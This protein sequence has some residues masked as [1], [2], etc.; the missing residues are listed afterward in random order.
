MTLTEGHPAET[1]TGTETLLPLTGAQLGIWNAQRLEP[2]SPYYLVGEVLELDGTDRDVELDLEVLVAEIAATVAEAETMRLRFVETADGPRQW[3]A[4][5]HPLAIPVVDLRAEADPRAAADE[6][7]AHIRADAARAASEMT[8]RQLFTYTLLRLSATQVWCVQLYHHLIVDGYSAAMISRRLATRYTATVTGKRLRPNTFGSIAELVAEDVQYRNSEQATLDRDYWTARLDPLPELHGRGGTDLGAAVRTRCAR[9]FLSTETMDELRKLAGDHGCTWADLLIG[10]YLGFVARLRSTTDVVSALPI[11]VRT[12]RTALT[13]PSMAVNVLP[14]RVSVSLSDDLPELGAK[15]AAALS[16]LREHQRYRGEDLVRDLAAPGAGAVLHGVGINLKA[17]DFDL[18]FAGAVGTLRNVAGGPPEELGLTATP[19]DGGRMMLGFEVDARTVSETEVTARV[20]GLARLVR[21]LSSPDRPA[22]GRVSLNAA[23]IDPGW[24]PAA[25]PQTGARSVADIFADMVTA[26][27][28]ETVL[29]DSEKSMTATE[30]AARSYR[31][32]RLLRARGIGTDD[33]VAIALP[34]TADIVACIFAVWEAGA[35]YVVLDPAYPTERLDGLVAAARP[36]LLLCHG[37]PPVT[38]IECEI[39]GLGSEPIET[40]LASLAGDRLRADELATTRRAD[41]M[42]YV[43]FTSGSTGTPKGVVVRSGGLAHLVHRQRTAVYADARARAGGRQLHVAHTTSFAFDASIDPLLWI[44]DGHRIH[45]YGSD[46]QRDADLQIQ[47]FAADAID[48]VDT[49]PSMAAFLVDAGLLGPAHGDARPHSIGT[50]VVGGEALPAALAQ[51]LGDSAARVYNMYGPTEATVDAIAAEVT[52]PDVRIGRPLEGTSAYLLDGALQPVLD[53]ETGELYLAGPQLARGYLGRPGA[54]ADRFVADPFDRSG[55]RMYRTGDLA[56]WHPETGFEYCGRA[57][58]QV[59][60]RGHRV[61]LREVETALTQSASVSAAVAVVTGA[62]AFA[63][64]VGYVVAA[65]GALSG[66]DVRRELLTRVPDH[67]VP[68]VVV[69]LDEMPVTVNGKIDR[70]RLPDPASLAPTADAAARTPGTAA[71]YALCAVVT[72]VLGV[73]EVSLDADLFTLGGDSIGAISISSRLRGHGLVLTP[74]ELLSGRDLATLAAMSREWVDDA[75]QDTDDGI[76]AAPTTPIMR[77]VLAADSVTA[78]AS[79]AQWAAVEVDRRLDRDAP[80]AA[81]RVLLDRH[82]ALRMIVRDAESVDIP[83]ATD[84][85]LEI[86]ERGPVTADAFTRE[87]AGWAREDAAALSPAAGDLLR[88]SI[89]RMSDGNDRLL[90]VVHHFAVD[91]VSWSVLLADLVAACRGLDLPPTTGESWRHRALELAA[92]GTVHRYVDELE[93]WQ[94][95]LETG[96]RVLVDADPRHGLDTHATA[97]VTRT[98]TTPAVTAAIIDALCSRYRARPDEVLLAAL[99]VAVR[100]YRD[101][102][103]GDFPVLMEGHG[104]DADTGRGRGSTV[105]W[106]TTEYPV[107]APAALL[108]SDDRLAEA[109][110]GGSVLAEILHEI[111]ARRRQ[112]RDHG[113]GYGVLRFHD[114]AGEPLTTLPAPQIVLNYLGRSA[115]LSGTGWRTVGDDGFGVVE[116]ATRTLT[117]VLA[118]N[119]FVHDGAAGSTLSIEWTAAGELL[120]ATSVAALQRHFGAALDAY[121]AH[122]ALHAGGLSAADC[123]DVI[124]TQNQV[125]FLE[126]ITGPLAEI[127]PLSPLQEGLLAHAARFT[128]HDPYTLTAVVDLAGEL[129]V[130]RLRSAFSA[131]VT[132][133]RNLAAGFHFDGVDAP[134]ATIPRVVDIP[135]RFSDLGQLP[136]VAAA[137]AAAQ[138]QRTAAARVFDVRRGPLLAA[139]VLRLPGERTQLILNAHHLVT[140]GWSTPIVLRELVHHYNHGAAGLPSAPDYADFLRWLGRLDRDGLRAAW[141]RRLAGLTAPTLVAR[142]E[143]AAGHPVTTEVPVDDTLGHRLAGAAR[144]NGLTVNT[145]VQGAWSAVLCALVGTD[146]VVFGTTVSGRPAALAQVESMVGLFSNTVPVR[147]RMDGRSLRD[148]LQDSQREQYDLGDAEHLPLSEIEACSD[149]RGGLFDTLV[150]F[151]NYPARF[152]ENSAD[153]GDSTHVTGIGN[154]STTQYPL[155]LLAPPGDRLRLVV[156]HDPGVVEARTAAMVVDA[157]PAVLADMVAGL[158]RPAAGFVPRTI[159]PL[160][161]RRVTERV[162]AVAGPAAAHAVDVVTACLA[163]VLETAMQPDDD[164]FDRGGHSLAAMRA[165]SGLRRHGVVVSV[166]DIFAARTPRVL[167]SRA[168][169]VET[170]ETP[171]APREPVVADGPDTVSSAQERLWVVQRLDPDSRAHDVPV[172]LELSAALDTDALRAAWRDLLEHFPVLRTCYPAGDGGRPEARVLS[173]LAIADLRERATDRDLAT[174][175]RLELA[176]TGFDL[177]SDVP[178]RATQLR[179]DGWSA[180]V[181]VIHHIAV[182][183]ASVPLLL[184]VLAQ[185]YVER[186]AGRNPQLL[187]DAPAF[188]EFVAADRARTRSADA[189]RS[190]RYWRDQLAALPT[191]L[192]LPTDRPRPR[193]ATHRSVEATRTLDAAVVDA[194]QRAAVRSGVSA[195]ML[196]E[197]AVAL[198]WQRFGAGTDIPLGTTVSDRE[199]L[200]EGRFRNTVGYLVNTTV[201]RID[202]AG[203]PTPGQV[204]ERVRTVGLDALAH[205]HVPFDRIVDAVAPERAAGRHPLFQTMVGHEIVGAP[206]ALGTVTGTPVEP[207]DPPARMDVAVWLREH[208]SHTD[209]RLGAAADLFDPDTVAHLADELLVSLTDLAAHPDRPIAALGRGQFRDDPTR[210]VTPPSVVARFLTQVRERPERTAVVA[211]G[212]ETTYREAGEHVETLARHLVAHGVR[213]GSVVGVAVGR[214]ADLPVALLAVLRC[215]AAY[216][217]LDV[218]YPRD[219]LQY[220]LDDARPV[221]VLVSVDTAD[222]VAWMDVPLIGVDA[223]GT[224]SAAEVM[225]PAVPA[226]DDALAYVIHT[227]GTTGKPKGVMVTSANLAAFADA[228][229]TLGWLRPD[230][231]LMAVTTVSFDIAVLELLCPLTVGASVVVAPR[232]SVVDPA[233]LAGLIADTGATVVQATPSLWRLLLTVPGTGR[234]RALI[235]GEAVPAELAEQL[236]TVSD[237]VWNVYGPTEATVWATTDRLTTGAPVTIGAPWIDVHARVLDDLL[238]EVPEG[239]FGELYLGGAQIARGYLNRPALTAARFVADPRRPGERLYRTGDAVRRRRG[240]IEYLRRTDDQ[241]K[242]RGFRI[243]LGEVETAMRALPDVADAAAKVAAIADGSARLFGYVVLRSG[244][245]ADPAR[246]RQELVS[247]WP[248]QFVPQSITVVET[249]PRTLNGKLDRAALP[250]PVPPPPVGPA[251]AGTGAAAPASVDTDLA[252][253][254]AEVLATEIDMASNFFAHGGDSIAAVRLVA[255]ASQRGVNIAVADVFECDTLAELAVRAVRADARTGGPDAPDAL[256]ELVETDASARAFVDAEYPGWQQVL[257]LTPLQ[258]G[259]YF[260]SVT[261]GRAATDNYHVQHR[262]TFAEP[263]ERRALSAALAAIVRRYPNL[264][265]AFT[266]SGFAEPVAIITPVSVVVEERT[267]DSA[268]G[269]DDVAAA[270]FARPFTLDQ[271]PLLRAVLVTGPESREQVV[272][273]QHHLLSDAW[274]QGVLFTELFVLYGVARM[275]VGL[276]PAGEDGDRQIADALARVLAPAADFTDHLRHLADRDTDA[277]TK[278]WAQHLA[279]LDEPTSV[280]PGADPFAMSLPHRVTCRIDDR[281]RDGIVSLAAELGITVSTVVSLAWA[282]T[283]RRVTGRDDVVFGS[284]VSGRD[285]RV[286]DVDRMVGLTLNTVPVRVRLRASSTL[287]DT[288]RRLFAEQSGLIEHH[289]AGLGEIARAAGFGVLFDTLL[290][291]RNVGGDAERFGVFERAG[292]VAAEATDA[293][294]YALTVDVDPRSRSGGMDVTI[295]NRPDLVDDETAASLLELMA[296]ML[297]RIAAIRTVDGTELTVA[298]TG[299]A[300]ES[301]ERTALT[302][303]RVPIPAPGAPEGS[304]DTLLSERAAAT[305]DAPALTCGAETFTARE[306]DERVTALARHLVRGGVGAGDLVALML[307]RIADHVV[308]IFAVMRTGAAY[309]PL[310]LEHPASR[311]REIVLDSGARTVVTVDARTDRVADVV[312]G[313]SAVSVVDLA[314]PGVADVLS[315]RRPGPEVPAHRIGGP[316]HPDQAAYV[317]YTSGSTGTPKGVQVGHR[318]L[319]TMYHNHRDEIFRA[320]ERSVDGRQLRI[321]HTVSFSFDM[322]WEELFWLLA[323]HHVHVIDEAARADPHTLVRHYRTVGIDVVNVTPSYARELIAAGLLDDRRAPKLVMLGGEAVPQE[324]WTRLREQDGVDGYD[325]YGPTEFT[326]NAMGSAVGDSATPC[327]GKPVRNA[328]ARVLDSGL[329]PVAVGAVGELY[330]SG[331][332]VAHGYRGRRGQTASVFVAD[333]F[334]VGERMYRTGDLVRYLDGGRLEYLGRVDRQVKIRGIR[335][336]LGEVESALEALPGV[337][338]AAATVRSYGATQ[339]LIGYVVADDST[340]DSTSESELRARLRDSVPAHLVPAQIVRVDAVPLTVNGK[341]DRAALPEPPRRN[342]AD[343]LRTPTQWQVAAA[344]C[345]LLGLDQVGADDG[346]ADCGGDSLAAMRLVS[347]IER[348]TSVRIAVGELLDRQS[349]A[350]I[351]E[352]VDSRRDGATT[353]AADDV[354]R[355]GRSRAADPLFCVH[356]AGGYAWQFASLASMLD[357]PVVGLQLPQGDRPGSFD[358]LV[359]HHLRTVRREQ[360]RGPYRLLGYSFGGTLAHAMAAVL[361]AAGETVAFVGVVDSEPLDGRSVEAPSAVRRLPVELADDIAENFTYTSSLLRTATAPVYPGTLTLFEAQRSKPSDGFAD[362]WGRIHEGELVV[363]AVD[364]DHDGIATAGGWR[365]ILPALE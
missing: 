196:L 53:G 326:I 42:A 351:A 235:G 207:V 226:A 323:G 162:P 150:V 246:M 345:E 189:E 265:A 69:V 242:V 32:A 179:G 101:A 206:V 144:E 87:I 318:G 330:M 149:A 300:G 350:A 343:S 170:S 138:A 313:L 36:S 10:A 148:V 321:A 112:G 134:V 111:K 209:I 332:G 225:L 243:E 154:I 30:L 210:E 19:V 328:C 178:A 215:G 341:L 48:V 29:T 317:I 349:V 79:Y 183:G 109:L 219:R 103:T 259:M 214:T 153:S 122:A 244:A 146:D 279:D 166:A 8:D 224:T 322:S 49:T 71:E 245:S 269:F 295:E 221:C 303:P 336:E 55:G 116:P 280:A 76:G 135:W 2:D 239:A 359:A 329:R 47:R 58:D 306:L 188:A 24:A 16:E 193:Q 282:L 70:K 187:T 118:V 342:V 26:C 291:F 123:D 251:P 298:R 191:E 28:N 200:A 240:R 190:L 54:T 13:T 5:N 347:R 310:D 75:G 218:D 195:L 68:S 139:H 88:L 114:E 33:I 142:G 126:S 100:A 67:L 260:H 299:R 199:L 113:I 61:E 211:G 208:G 230:D 59:K 169:A 285:P 27:P 271:A 43:L 86:G 7:V 266:H 198:T 140:D 314:D 184:E 205:Q 143:G 237:E 167:A 338:R 156:D 92:R 233:R 89:V 125:S 25:L 290:V 44:L 247:A 74:K 267:V 6:K 145:F 278:A 327:L 93:Q 21:A 1:E 305:P 72:E 228:V 81:A 12:T 18:D 315:G 173:P 99:T 296:G 82:P 94:S 98:E 129:D 308:A 130:D 176:D 276:H 361:T 73:P 17:F 248:D 124:V 180:L 119:A 106:F 66:D 57:D 39:V 141:R 110:G 363:H 257:P 255:A 324:L 360:P 177:E 192:E 286:P 22:L 222:G 64:L 95:V 37:E 157:L 229:S 250:S 268:D 90:V 287:A 159:D 185:A 284:T 97:D 51:R 263:V 164:F 96:S 281:V 264:G 364:E 168:R 353:G 78:V 203:N 151:E 121:A 254:A 232:A 85:P 309:L 34:R 333:P 253:A 273:T 137:A 334:A 175:V 325:L 231:R 133:H 136:A 283:L 234:V 20:R 120:G 80:A 307:P 161:A 194:L 258:R 319:T 292:I 354:I 320:T 277:A 108:D 274:S 46:V 84:V 15:V 181:I 131:V 202:L 127:L 62:G 348:D 174:A 344:Y 31:I 236:T 335:I 4:P 261:G 14:L 297:A 41:D 337:S 3:I 252:A 272:L 152:G 355:F 301:L 107:S 186:L 362:R 23:G 158:D 223:G 256:V 77:N 212:R 128:E 104:R 52:G 357:R 65:D 262:F 331:D 302:T 83:T 155:S 275:L 182:D 288:L 132:R 311:L 38:T 213:A 249:L 40:E 304:I 220:M 365:Q 105:G 56:R 227:S 117:E 358:E 163:E 270:E 217:P 197:A 340:P 45:L 35:A 63:K 172:V 293:T 316:T 241:V 201:H 165:V 60:I 50:I 238:R 171:E 339:R 294:H 102:A 216:L 9:A 91:A 356:P 115:G 11:M 289:H 204:L 312:A 147:V 160:P 352:L 346:F